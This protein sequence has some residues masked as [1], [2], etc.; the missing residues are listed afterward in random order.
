MRTEVFDACVIF[1]K[2]PFVTGDTTDLLHLLA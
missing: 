2:R 1:V